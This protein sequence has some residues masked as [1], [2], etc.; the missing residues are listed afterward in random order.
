M[1]K[2]LQLIGG[3][4]TGGGAIA[5]FFLNLGAKLVSKPFIIGAQIARMVAL[6]VA[7]IAFLVAVVKFSV[8]TINYI[9]SFLHD[10]SSYF[11]SDTLLSLG[12]KV[13]ESLGIIDAFN[14]AFAIFN[15]LFPALIGAWALKFSYKIYKMAS[16]EFYKLGALLQA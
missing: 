4:F 5:S 7:Y 12:F 3:F 13:F 10:M 8:K 1:L 16:D 11:N 6:F 2:I 14:D 9:N 15:I